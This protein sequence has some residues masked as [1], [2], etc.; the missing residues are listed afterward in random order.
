MNNFYLLNE[1]IDLADFVAF[2]EGM[3]ELNAIEKEN[4]DNFWKHDD[5][6]NLRVIEILFSTYGQEEQVISQFLMQIT[7]KNG[8]YLGDEESLDNF[9][10]NELNAFLGIDFSL[11]DC[12][13]GEKQIIDN[14]TFQLIKKNDLWNVTYRNMWSKKEKLFPNLIFC[15][16]VEKQLLL[17]GDS[18]YFNQIIDRLVVFNK[19][20]S[21]WKEGSFSYKTINANYSL[22]IS[23]ESDKTMS[24]F[25]NE[26]ICKLPDGNTEY[27]ELHIKTGDLR[28]HFYADDCV[29]KVYIGYIGPHLNTITG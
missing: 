18:S 25:G 4:D 7:S 19:A 3:L 21:L 9:F 6:W 11:I 17:I 13:R 26:R 23:P 16:D 24:K 2:K 8:V 14:N 20:V 1:A 28:F 15:E 10:P 12:I 29:K 5:V 27:F 22:R